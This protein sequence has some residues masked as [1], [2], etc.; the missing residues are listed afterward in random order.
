MYQRFNAPWPL[1]GR[2]LFIEISGYV[3]PFE[4]SF[5]FSFDSVDDT[6]WFGAPIKKN[7]DYVEMIFNKSFGYLKPLGP[8]Q[9]L[10]KF[11][12]S[13]DPQLEYVPPGIIDWGIKTISGGFLEYLVNK[14]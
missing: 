2:E 6:E 14:C 12:I 13:S 7:K 1:K 4:D 9:T 11:I 10:F 8:N 5:I 3:L